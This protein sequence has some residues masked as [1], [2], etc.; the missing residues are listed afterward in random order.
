[1]P[2]DSENSNSYRVNRGGTWGDSPAS[3]RVAIRFRFVPY[4]RN[5]YLGFRLVEEAEEAEGTS[6]NRV[7]RGGCWY[8]VAS[9]ARVAL[10][11]H[12]D[13]SFRIDFL[14]FRLVEEE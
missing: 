1:M 6:S 13:P 5:F 11:F 10:R 2:T 4:F 12:Y 14:G 7:R 3:A 8:S 9:F